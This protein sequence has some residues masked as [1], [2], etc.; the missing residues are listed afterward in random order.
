M[1]WRVVNDSLLIGR[2][3]VKAATQVVQNVKAKRKI[4]VFDFVCL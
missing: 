3:S 4:A 1:A 2:Y